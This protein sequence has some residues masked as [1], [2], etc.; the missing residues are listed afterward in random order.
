[1]SRYYEALPLRV[2]TRTGFAAT[3]TRPNTGIKMILGGAR[4]TS[5]HQALSAM[6]N[7]QKHCSNTCTCVPTEDLVVFTGLYVFQENTKNVGK[8][9]SIFTEILKI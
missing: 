2:Q 3:Q 8:Q 4:P 5:N 9:L 1:M 6:E 7:A